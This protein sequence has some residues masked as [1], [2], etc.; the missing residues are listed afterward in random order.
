M[1]IQKLLKF[2]NIETVD[3]VGLKGGLCLLWNDNIN[4]HILESSQNWL[5]CFVTLFDQSTF[6][7]TGVYGPPKCQDRHILWNYLGQLH[8]CDL[9]WILCGDFNQILNKSEKLSRCDTSRG[10]KEFANFLN[11]KSLIEIPSSGNWF[12]WTNNRKFDDVVWERLDRAICNFE[13]I[14]WLPHTYY[15]VLPTASDHSPILI[16]MEQQHHAKKRY[17][18]FEAMWTKHESCKD[19]IKNAWNTTT[20]GSAAYKLISKQKNTAK[21]LSQWNKSVFGNITSQIRE[22]EQ[23]LKILQ[24]NLSD[25]TNRI[26]E[27]N[28][29]SSLNK[30]LDYEETMWAQRESNNGLFMVTVIP[31]SSMR[32][33]QKD[34]YEIESIVLKMTQALGSMTPKNCYLLVS[35]SSVNFSQIKALKTDPLSSISFSSREFQSSLKS[36]NQLL[37]LP[38]HDL[39]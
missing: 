23:Q 18:K 34:G 9:P 37:L 31:S 36:I 30:L 1:H 19:V 22:L 12:T 8:P 21:N 29:R 26:A 13:W 28:I 39:K 10:H 24:S 15:E 5:T 38:S 27:S 20:Q 25:P 4:V 3:A 6:L 35:T 2:D 7:F 16:H 14:N 32:L 11:Q 17:F 33:L